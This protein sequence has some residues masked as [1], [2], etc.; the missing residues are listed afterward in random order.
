MTRFSFFTSLFFS[1]FVVFGTSNHTFAQEEELF[2]NRFFYGGLIFGGNL[3]QV[4]G[5]NFAGFNRFGF[6]TGTI[7]YMKLHRQTALSLEILLSQKGSVA[8]KAIYLANGS[9]IQ[10]YG[11]DLTY[12]EVP[13]MINFFDKHKSNFGIGLS[14]AQLAKSNEYVTA[15]PPLAYDQE[16]HPFNKSDINILA[17]GNLRLYKGLYFNIRFQYSILPIRDQVEDVSR[18]QQYNNMWTLR[19]MYLFM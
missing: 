15:D 6:N 11:I 12:A 16:K 7:V 8:S 14:Y 2:E 10:K 1:L 5:D 9:T 19:L 4:D 17:G 13:V 3:T 18:A